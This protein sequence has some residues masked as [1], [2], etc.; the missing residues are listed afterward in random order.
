LLPVN[1]NVTDLACPPPPPPP[2]TV[3]LAVLVPVPPGVVTEIGP[4]VAPLGT[5]AVICVAELTVYDVAATPLNLTAVAPV[6]FVPVMT[7]DVPTGPLV[8]VKLVIVGAPDVTVKTGVLPVPPWFCTAM[9]P[10]VAPV[11][12]VAVSWLLF[13]TV[14]V[15]AAVTPFEKRTENV[16][17]R[18]DPLIVTELPTAP[19]VGLTVKPVG[20]TDGL[21]T[22]KLEALVAFPDGAST[23]MVP[24]T[25]PAGTVA[26]MTESEF[27]TNPGAFV[28]PNLT[29]VAGPPELKP[30]PLIVTDVPT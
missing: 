20:A 1:E 29:A 26:V 9:K 10:V 18:F 25:A 16:P 6:K 13:E 3:K 14:N 22:S 5:V 24:S 27:T 30:E 12:T 7:T 28:P 17:Q 19:V 4:V 21:T 15:V 11:G 2:D 23:A 8:G